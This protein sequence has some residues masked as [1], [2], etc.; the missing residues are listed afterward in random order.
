MERPKGGGGGGLKIVTRISVVFRDEKA[1]LDSRI[2]EKERN[3][4]FFV[5]DD[6]WRNLRGA[7]ILKFEIVK[8]SIFISPH[9]FFSI[10]MINI[11]SVISS[12]LIPSTRIKTRNAWF[13]K[14]EIAF[15]T[16]QIRRIH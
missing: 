1:D 11:S 4:R 16:N 6:I 7:R 3:I 2:R 9:R 8:L 10:I 15:E 14:E 13:S 5:D 12:I